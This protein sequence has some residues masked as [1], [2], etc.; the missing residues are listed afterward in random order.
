MSMDA[1]GVPSRSLPLRPGDSILNSNFLAGGL[2]RTGVF[3]W[4]IFESN[5][6]YILCTVGLN[7][8]TLNGT[9]RY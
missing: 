8:L 9:K 7:I 5:K 2:G 1:A 4:I 3:Y 6:I